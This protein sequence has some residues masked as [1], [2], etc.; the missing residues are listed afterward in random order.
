MKNNFKQTGIRPKAVVFKPHEE[1]NNRR[2]TIA[3]FRRLLTVAALLCSHALLAAEPPAPRIIDLKASDGTVLKATYFAAG[4]PGPGVLLMH[5]C[6][7]NRQMWND[8]APKLAA[9]GLNVLTLDFRGFGESGG[10]APYKLATAQ[11]A[12]KMLT[13]IFPGDVDTAFTFL[14]SQYGV[15]K[16]NI[17]AAGSSCGVNQAIQLA[18]RHGEVKSLMLLSGF[19]DRDGRAFLKQASWLPIFGVAADDDAGAV[20]QME[21]LLSIAPNIGNVFQHYPT[22]GH[23]I[24]MFTPHPELNGLLLNWFKTTLITTPGHAPANRHSTELRKQGSVFAILDSPGGAVK[25]SEQLAVARRKDPNAQL[26]SESAAN[27]IGYEHLQ[28][29]DTTGAIQIFKLNIAAN[30]NSPNVYDSLADAY[31]TTGDKD[32][33]RQN[34]QKA[35]DL[36]AGDSADNEAR[37][38]AIRESAEQKLK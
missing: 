34:A 18:R 13:E 21:W 23:G 8:L 9:E 7:R 4:K 19:T 3:M 16:N 22:G 14:T 33:A 30:P 1:F 35:I 6:N 27:I 17:G 15:E 11:E 2:G 25:L 29:G 32:L 20:D 10:T 36:L 31:V 24:E 28:D 5:Q 12:N 38:K 26:F 37:K